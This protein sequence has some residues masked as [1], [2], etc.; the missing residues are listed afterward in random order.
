VWVCVG[1]SERRWFDL[2]KSSVVVVVVGVYPNKSEWKKN[3]NVSVDY[4]IR[5][6]ENKDKQ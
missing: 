5:T 1:V 3:I 2:V 4:V 6:R